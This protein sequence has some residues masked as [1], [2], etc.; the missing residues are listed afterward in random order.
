MNRKKS[1][2]RLGSQNLGALPFVGTGALSSGIQV[3]KK[4]GINVLETSSNPPSALGVGG[5]MSLNQTQKIMIPKKGP[6]KV[7]K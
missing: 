5:G 1:F 7:L 2:S 4:S 6:I 3:V